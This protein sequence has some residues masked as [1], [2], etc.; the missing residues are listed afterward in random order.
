[1]I[2]GCKLRTQGC[3][4][5]AMG[6]V[7]GWWERERRDE[8]KNSEGC[9]SSCDCNGDTGPDYPMD[10]YAQDGGDWNGSYIMKKDT[11]NGRR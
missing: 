1:M 7:K 4:L 5:I 10:Y 6:F 11:V 2:C 9:G 8:P 3:P